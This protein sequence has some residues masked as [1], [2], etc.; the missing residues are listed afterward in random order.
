MTADLPDLHCFQCHYKPT[1]EV[2]IRALVD[3]QDCESVICRDEIDPFNLFLELLKSVK[4]LIAKMLLFLDLLVMILI[5]SHSI[6]SSILSDP[7]H[8]NVCQTGRYIL[9]RQ[10][11]SGAD[12]EAFSALRNCDHYPV[13][14]KQIPQDKGPLQRESE[15][16]E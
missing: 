1:F 13:C 12:G 8:S 6:S 3:F 9:G 2:I 10:L 16:P 15:W 11:G 7:R 5:P 4:K 14:I